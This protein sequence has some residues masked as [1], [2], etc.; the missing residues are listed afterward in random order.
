M[1]SLERR[2]RT[3]LQSA[4]ASTIWNTP[5]QQVRI[6]PIPLRTAY[7]CKFN[8]LRVIL[9]LNKVELY[10]FNKILIVLKRGERNGLGEGDQR[11]GLEHMSF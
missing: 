2:T 4:Q 3:V 9:T 5:S 6:F 7:S 11:V 10:L 8:I 1:D